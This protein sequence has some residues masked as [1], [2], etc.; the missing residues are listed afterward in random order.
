MWTCVGMTPTGA[1][2]S[3]SIRYEADGSAKLALDL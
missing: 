3:S 2:V 1:G